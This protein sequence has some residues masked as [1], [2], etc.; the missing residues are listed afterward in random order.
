MELMW[1]GR[2][3]QG[4]QEGCC[5]GCL[6]HGSEAA[7]LAGSAASTASHSMT[8]T[9]DRVIMRWSVCC[10]WFEHQ[11]TSFM[12]ALTLAAGSM[13]VTSTLMICEWPGC[14]V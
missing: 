12:A 4:E 3:G 5:V 13:S 2:S 7:G 8:R 14:K 9:A 6:G 10:L 11:P 1:R